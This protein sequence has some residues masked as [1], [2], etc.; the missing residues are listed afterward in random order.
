MRFSGARGITRTRVPLIAMLA[1][2]ATIGLA[3]CEGD[4]GKDGATGPQGPT[5]STGVTGPTG[6]TGATGAT[7]PTG[8]VAGIEKPLESCAVCHG[9]NSL[10]SADEA[11][12]MTGKV[13]V[14][15]VAFAV[16]G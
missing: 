3:G 13:A 14:A 11:H 6:P 4:D 10:A 5:G 15:N 16:N 9:D 1:L 8:P 12:A 2:A 7:G